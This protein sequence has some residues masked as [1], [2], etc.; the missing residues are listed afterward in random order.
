MRKII[1]KKL[2]DTET[3]TLLGSICVGEF[4]DPTG[5]EEKLFVTKTKQHFI[6][7][8]GG[9]ESK[10]VKPTIELFTDE[11]AANWLKENKQSKSNRKNKGGK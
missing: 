2:C 6:H 10:Y 9:P 1:N 7:G 8:V 5:Y 11:E 4:G 3:A